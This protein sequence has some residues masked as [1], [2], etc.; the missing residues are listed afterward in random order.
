MVVLLMLR[1]LWEGLQRTGETSLGLVRVET[2]KQATERCFI[3]AAFIA[4]V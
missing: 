1:E 4:D 3:L 2:C